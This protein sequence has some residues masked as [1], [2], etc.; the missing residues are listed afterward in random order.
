MTSISQPG[1]PQQIA[2]KF[3]F[4]LIKQPL[5]QAFV[6]SLQPKFKLLSC[7]T[8]KTNITALYQLMK[9]KLAIE[10]MTVNQ[11]LLTTDPWTS[12][13]SNQTPFMVVK[14]HC[15][16]NWSLKKQVI[17]FKELPTPH[18]GISIADQLISTI[19]EWKLVDTVIFIM[20]DNTSSNDVVISWVCLKQCP[21]R[22]GWEVFPC[23]MCGT[24][25]QSDCEGWN[26]NS[27]RV[28]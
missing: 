19:M 16:T 28:H 22:F 27:F 17:A 1:P 9:M 2:H 10:L 11:T 3:P 8:L 20:M 14:S 6:E 18:N 24:Y 4:M 15:I 5:I 23:L 7:G 12:S 21:T 26:Q 25:N 13:E